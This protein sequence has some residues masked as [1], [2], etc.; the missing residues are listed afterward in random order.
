MCSLVLVKYKCLIHACRAKGFVLDVGLVSPTSAFWLIIEFVHGLS[1]CFGT[2]SEKLRV[3][4]CN[5]TLDGRWEQAH[6]LFP[7]CEQ[8]LPLT[9][10]S[11]TVLRFP[12]SQHCA[13][14]II[15][16][17]SR[18]ECNWYEFII[19]MTLKQMKFG[20]QQLKVNGVK[21]W[22]HLQMDFKEIN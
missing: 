22:I 14:F 20:F 19:E 13:Y 8:L 21:I 1:L 2:D 9:S 12:R 6:Q 10:S 15:E 18:R 3:W 7:S 5:V 16:R 11:K 4:I 17:M